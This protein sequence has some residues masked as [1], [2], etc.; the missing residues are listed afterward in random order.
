M[1]LC[2]INHRGRYY[3]NMFI[4]VAANLCL[5]FQ[6]SIWAFATL[7]TKKKNFWTYDYGIN[8]TPQWDNNIIFP[9]SQID[10]ED[11]F[12][13]APNNTYLY[14]KSIY[15]YYMKLPDRI[16]Q[17]GVIEYRVWD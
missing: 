4:K 8:W 9:L 17:H 1:G 14:L 12:F 11:Y 15:G 3:D 7:V 16:E 2:I 13:P 6:K 5:S 10:F